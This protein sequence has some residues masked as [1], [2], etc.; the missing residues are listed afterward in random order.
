M[1]WQNSKAQGGGGGYLDEFAAIDGRTGIFFH[2]SRIL[3]LD[4]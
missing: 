2:F 4:T 3:S 1:S